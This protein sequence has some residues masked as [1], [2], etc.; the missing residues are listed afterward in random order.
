MFIY[1]LN[2]LNDSLRRNGHDNN[3][4]P[5]EIMKDTKYI[6]ELGGINKN[7]DLNII[8]DRLNNIVELLWKYNLSFKETMDTLSKLLNNEKYIWILE[9]FNSSNVYSSNI[10]FSSVINE[11]IQKTGGNIEVRKTNCIAL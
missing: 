5:L 7:V 6:I 3:F 9:H 4:L 8:S 2:I 1:I 10:I 11:I